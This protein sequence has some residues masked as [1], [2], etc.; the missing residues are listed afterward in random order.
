MGQ[1]LDLDELAAGD[2]EQRLGVG[3]FLVE[4][5]LL[6]LEALHRHGFGGVCLEQPV[7]LFL[8][9]GQ[10]ALVAGGLCAVLGLQGGD[11]VVDGG[12]GFGD[13]GGAELDRA[14]VALDGLLDVLDGQ[15]WELAAFAAAEAE[16]VGVGVA[17]LVAGEVVDHAPAA[18]AAV[19]RALQIMIVGASLLAGG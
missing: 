12:L 6:A 11:V 1:P 17:L 10:R 3:G 5:V 8:D 18:V 19:D 7:E 15:V 2:V 4:L 9:R 13:G 16:E 14:V